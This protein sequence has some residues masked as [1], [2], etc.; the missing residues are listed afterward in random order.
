MRILWS[1][2]LYPPVHNCGSEWMAHNINKHLIAQ[3]HEVRVILHQAE[4]HKVPVPYILD[5]VEVFPPTGSLD[6]YRWADVI[7][8]HLDY[9]QFTMIMA[10]EAKKPLFH[11]IHND[12]EYTC[13]SNAIKG[14]Y[15]VY[16][17]KWISD[18]LAYKW[19]SMVLHPPCDYDAYNVNDNPE[20]SEFITLISLNRN[21]GGEQFYRIAE[22]MPHKKFLGV[23]G[24]YDE[25]VVRTDLPNVTIL[26]N[27][28]DIWSVYKKTRILLM[29]SAY[30]S[31]GRTATEAMCN[32]IP[33]I[34]T[35]TPGLKENCGE[36]GVFVKNRNNINA[37]V[38]EIDRLDN[39]NYYQKLSDKARQRAKD[40]KPLSELIQLEEMIRNAEF[41]N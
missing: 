37:W 6:T 10:H 21:K 35:P 34:C 17:S 25:Q 26:P 2:H 12:I 23:I 41:N 24:S 16:N 28:P 39:K 22:A 36:A 1:I 7:C 15:V 3:G 11:F 13:I 40:L 33:V 5:G 14:N 32:G 30:E 20:E 31:W 38:R 19:P 4:M 8:T 18:K 29:P 9:T 27:T